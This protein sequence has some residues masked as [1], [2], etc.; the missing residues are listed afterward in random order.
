MMSSLT[1][2]ERAEFIRQQIPPNG[3]FAGHQW[4]ISPEPFL[5]NRELLTELEFLGRVLL[6]FYRA[7]NLVY[8]RS[9]AGEQTAWIAQTLDRGK[10]HDLIE[11][12]PSPGVRNGV[13][14][15]IRPDILLTD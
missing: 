8:R 7:V 13:P 10:P 12:Q 9:V 11:L 4:R 3:L 6:Q 15:I 2:A 14:R 1:P 5:I